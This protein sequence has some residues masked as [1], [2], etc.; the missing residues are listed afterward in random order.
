MLGRKALIVKGLD[1]FLIQHAGGRKARGD[2]SRDSSPH[3]AGTGFSVPTQRLPRSV[4]IKAGTLLI[5]RNDIAGRSLAEDG[6]Q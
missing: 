1:W 3:D 6:F 4:L 5:A 2:S